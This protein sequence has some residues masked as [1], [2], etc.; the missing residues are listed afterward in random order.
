MPGFRR[1]R[2]EEKPRGCE[3]PDAKLGEVWVTNKPAE[4]AA[5]FAEQHGFRIGTTAYNK[6]SAVVPGFKPIFGPVNH[7]VG[8]SCQGYCNHKHGEGLKI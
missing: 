1:T 5:L 3:H 6:M 7:D 2:V 4:G 8:H